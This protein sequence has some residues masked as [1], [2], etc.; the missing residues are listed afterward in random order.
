MSEGKRIVRNIFLLIIPTVLIIV[1]VNVWID[2]ANIYS[3]GKYE[4]GIVSL[5]SEGNNVTNIQNYNER[6]LQKKLIETGH[7][8]PQ[9]LI[10]GSSRVMEIGSDFF[11]NKTVMNN[12][13]SFAI[14]EDDL[15]IL[16]LYL[17]QG[18]KPDRIILGLDPWTLN[19]N[20]PENRWIYI[21]P[22][23]Y[24]DMLQRI[25][26]EQETKLTDYFRINPYYKEMFS[27]SYFQESIKSKIWSEKKEQS[28]YTATKTKINKSYTKYTD[29]SIRYDLKFRNKTAEELKSFVINNSESVI[30]VPLKDFNEISKAK[31]KTL[32]KLV[33][34]CKKN[35]IQIE[36]LLTPFHPYTYK[37][38]LSKPKYSLL[39]M[40]EETY[41]KI[42]ANSS[43]KL[44]G[45]FDPANLNLND[46]LFYDDMH[47]KVS[48]LRKI[49]TINE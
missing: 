9:L 43:I 39:P 6:Y 23:E 49:L 35:G 34:F 8:K 26:D 22:V 10:I 48:A 4:N 31:T 36:F 42:A 25:G 40:T 7:F 16:N 24:K 11:K 19:D 15:A 12:G 2:P 45:S 29:G 21:Y 3:L 28:E 46:S 37:L 47:C 1:S 17:K 44:Y 14:L 27:F 38:L 30:E 41:K 5:M 20:N 13:V 18:I 32:I 33:A